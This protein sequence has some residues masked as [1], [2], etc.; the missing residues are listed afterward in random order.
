MRDTKIITLYKN[1]G[2]HGDF[3]NYQG[4]SL[5]CIV[6][7]AFACVVL[8]RLQSLAERVYPEAQ[9]RFRAR[10]SIIDMVFSLQ[11]LQERCWEQRRL[12]YVTFND[13]TKAFDLVSRKGL[14]TL[15]QKTGCSPK[16]LRMITSFHEDMQSTVQY[17]GSSSNPFLNNSGVK[18]VCSL[19]HLTLAAAVFRLQPVREWNISPHHK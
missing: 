3:N 18:T 5:L 15:L 17:N 2:D 11:Q 19:Q 4:I 8:N 14:F 10:R 7:K 12:L 16:L 9:Y 13:L 1:K 6:G